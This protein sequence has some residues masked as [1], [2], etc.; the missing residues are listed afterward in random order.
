MLQ[1]HHP[2]QDIAMLK[3]R[4]IHMFAG[5]ATSLEFYQ[6]WFPIAVGLCVEIDRVLGEYRKSFHWVQ[7]KEKF[8]VMCLY[9]DLQGAPRLL[10]KS[11]QVLVPQAQRE[12]AQCC[13]RHRRPGGGSHARPPLPRACRRS[14]RAWR[15]AARMGVPGVAAGE[16]AH[17]RALAGY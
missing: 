6:G 16:Q 3:A 11:R 14:R 4:F 15:V 8:G 5:P 13:S 2:T 12:S 7:I 17:G 9:F 10:C 1:K